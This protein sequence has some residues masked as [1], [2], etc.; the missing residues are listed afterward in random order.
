MQS[1]AVKGIIILILSLAGLGFVYYVNVYGT[2]D[3]LADQLAGEGMGEL[4]SSPENCQE[5]CQSNMGRCQLYCQQ[6]P[7]N[8][9]CKT[10]I[11]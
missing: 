7:T 4:C 9:L 3:Y 10:L 2:L 1:D 8:P 11:K 6:N 5:F